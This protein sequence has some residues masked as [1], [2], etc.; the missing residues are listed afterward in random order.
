MSNNRTMKAGIITYWNTKNNYGTIL[1]NYALQV[2]LRSH[3][4]ETF[5][6]RINIPVQ[7]SRWKYY[8]DFLKR[9]GFFPF[10]RYLGKRFFFK[11]IRI[12]DFQNKKNN[13]RKIS[14]FINENLKATV[15]FD[16]LEKLKSECPKADVYVAGSD[17]IWNTYGQNYIYFSEQIK[18]YLLSFVPGFAKKITCAAS[19]GTDILDSNF[20][21]LFKS[22]LSKF[23]FISC[24]E[25][26]GVEICKNLG[27][28]NTV[29]QQ[30]P[31]MLLSVEDYKKISSDNFTSK[32]PY[33]LLY[34]LGNTTDF[35]IC[36]LKHFAKEKKLEIV[37]VPANDLQKINFYKK[38]Y[39]T[40][41][42]WLG[43][44]KNASFVVTNSF[45]G[46]VFSLIFNKPFL[47]VHQS[48]EF[49]KQNVRIDSLLEDFGLLERL[50]DGNFERL[51][52]LVDFKKINSRLEEIREKSPFVEYIKMKY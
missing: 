4:F 3:G 7:C 24:R 43:L 26:S 45:H 41:N 20:E 37:Y 38:T 32:R 25:K 23:D 49:S 30:D 18:S 12:F 2:F 5:L 28:G 16:S 44:Y 31:T 34:L 15:I 14:D 33:I 1:Q 47:A 19:F 21:N 17:Q 42:E 48:G 39:P 46:T 50:F 9:N 13:K 11:S 6:I 40:V 35:S 27:L 22:E 10:V 51:F 29:L 52:K 36:K 8:K